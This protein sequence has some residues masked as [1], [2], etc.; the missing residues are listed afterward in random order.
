MNRPKRI[1]IALAIL[2]LWVGSTHIS[3]AQYLPSH[4]LTTRSSPAPIN[5]N[6]GKS[7]AISDSYMV[8]AEQTA[9]DIGV[10][11]VFQAST[12]RFLR[13]LSVTGSEGGGAFGSSLA[14]SGKYII[15]GA[16]SANSGR[17]LVY[18]FDASTGRK[19]RTLEATDGV[20]GVG[21]GAGDRFGESV[22]IFGNRVLVGAPYQNKAGGPMDTG[23]AYL[24][25]LLSGVQLAKWNASDAA[26]NLDQFGCSVSISGGLAVVGAWG[27][28][29]QTGAAYLFDVESG[30]QLKKLI[31]SDRAPGHEFGKSVSLFGN[32]VLVGAPGN[33]L[34][35]AAY[36]FN[37][38]TGTHTHKIV[39]AG[40]SATP[41]RFGQCVSMFAD[42]AVV[43]VPAA[44]SNAGAAVWLDV[45]SPGDIVTP[46]VVSGAAPNDLIGAAVAV[47]ANRAIIGAP[48]ESDVSINAGAAYLY[49]LTIASRPLTPIALKGSVAPG[50]GSAKY[51]TLS[52]P[53]ISG[54]GSVAYTSTL[55][56]TGAGTGSVATG[57][58]AERAGGYRLQGRGG[59]SLGIGTMQTPRLPLFN[60]DDQIVFQSKVSGTGI[61]TTN[62]EAVF[63]GSTVASYPLLR[64]NDSYIGGFLGDTAL[65]S[66]LETV[67]DYDFAGKVAA[68]VRRKSNTLTRVTTAN[69]TGVV[70]MVPGGP[71]PFGIGEGQPRT[72]GSD[73]RWG[74]VAPR[75]AIM[76][77]KIQWSSALVAGPATPSGMVSSST[78]QS[79]AF[80]TDILWR[81]GDLAA[82]GANYR[83]FLAAAV[84]HDNQPTFKATLTGSGVTT[85]TNEGI[86]R[87]GLGQVVRKNDPLHTT[88]FPGIK[89]SRILKFWSLRNG[90][91]I[92][93]ARLAGTRVSTAN[94]VALVLANPYDRFYVLLREGDF[95]EGPDR[96][97]IGSIQ[98]V[99]VE[100]V[101]SQYV[102]LASLTGNAA[103][104][105]ALFTGR[106]LD[107]GPNPINPRLARAGLRLRKGSSYRTADSDPVVVEKITSMS[108][109]NTTDS[110]GAGAKGLGQAIEYQ[111]TVGL[112]IDYSKGSREIR[113]GVP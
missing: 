30:V 29:S 52:P 7:V 14:I 68:S 46:L 31:A 63:S 73:I 77:G 57:L 1:L 49:D 15:V 3:R 42:R 51:G 8:C 36:L 45:S 12:R 4:T 85:A 112:T 20:G 35:G 13:K 71:L 44:N 38:Q 86:Y 103:T 69:D 40:S 62:D 5:G 109:T 107:F 113:K 91:V 110:T 55:T 43:G 80:D 48:G 105:Q 64:E 59:Y 76:N 26:T 18:I 11:N 108:I 34:I 87:F 66:F 88:D 41:V 33:G 23:A 89:I 79:L 47:S 10:I 81:S 111:G 102:V 75:L 90:Q 56:G 83:S 65:S 101:G 25:D 6:F 82:I 106:T 92:F 54:S 78:N 98:K 70:T 22:A 95:A 72:A 32:K 50:A 58:W 27:D 21:D 61:T 28:N 24:F 16:P 99:D 19:L 39:L 74:Q 94:D 9:S 2:T 53:V 84:S 67:Q 97:K 96:A 100:P 37:C 104:N 60:D 17:G 93:L